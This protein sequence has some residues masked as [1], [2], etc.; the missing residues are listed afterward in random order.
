MKKC[1]N[2]NSKIDPNAH[3]ECVD[4]KS[5]LCIDCA[6]KTKMICPVCYNELRRI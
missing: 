6:K 1:K 5:K 2:C 4:C 3:F